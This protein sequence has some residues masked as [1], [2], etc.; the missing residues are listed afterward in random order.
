MNEYFN[1]LS[2]KILYNT[3]EKLFFIFLNILLI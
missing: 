2:Y 3:K 1:I